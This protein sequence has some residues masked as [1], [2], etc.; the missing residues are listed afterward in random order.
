MACP[1][2]PSF[3]HVQWRTLGALW[4]AAGLLV[5]LSVL[6]GVDTETDRSV[7]AALGLLGIAVGAAMVL[8]SR[9]LPAG[10]MWVG[11]LL[12]I[13]ATSASVVGAGEPDTPFILLFAWI[14]MQAW[15]F[16]PPRVAGAMTALTVLATA[17]TMWGI[18]QPEDGVAAWWA[19]V[20]GTIATTSTMVAVLRRRSDRLVAA[21]AEAASRDALTGLLNRGAFAELGAAEL[22]RAQRRGTPLTVVL[23]DLDSFKCLNDRFGHQRGDDALRAFAA[24]LGEHAR[25]GDISARVGGEEFALMLPDTDAAGAVATAERLRKAVRG[26]LATP[27][28]EPVTVSFG[29]AAFPDDGNDLHAL[30][31]SA[32]HALYA[33]KSLGRDTTVAFGATAGAPTLQR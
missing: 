8:A 16:L 19:M 7:V 9:R 33:A 15:Y 14:G 20:M 22:A 25:K 4:L 31:G 23:G 30:V 18:A 2:S 12:A 1:S 27:D 28:G 26:R 21:L 29:V 17:A 24:L 32:D 13:G 6:A 5:H 3:G 10:L 11:L